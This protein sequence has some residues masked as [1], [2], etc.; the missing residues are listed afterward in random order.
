ML[1]EFVGPPQIA[2]LIVLAQR[3]VE[4]LHSQRNTRALLARGAREIGG[5]YYSVVAVTH[6]A[7]IAG[8]ASLI[9]PTA[10]VSIPWLGVYALLT[11]LRYWTIGTLGQYWTHRIITLDRAPVVRKGPYRY[12]NHPNYAIT[13]AETFVLPMAFGAIAFALII[14]AVWSTVLA[15]KIRL[16]NTGLAARTPE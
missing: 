12:I 7:W 11:V 6:L 10:P 1:A 5:D 3:G 13:I 4:E 14:T 2:A 8:L 15:Y 16:E 9:P